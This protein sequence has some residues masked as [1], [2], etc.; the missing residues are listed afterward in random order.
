MYISAYNHLQWQRNV[1]L[2]HINGRLSV[3]A[4]NTV[5]SMKTSGMGEGTL[6]AAGGE[7]VV[8]V[9]CMAAFLIISR[10]S[11]ARFLTAVGTEVL[12]IFIRPAMSA[13]GCSASR[14]RYWLARTYL[15]MQLAS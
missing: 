6:T 9:G 4:D 14:K 8:S 11:L 7:I 15:S 2:D 3:A 10:T 5:S 13:G 1:R 12:N